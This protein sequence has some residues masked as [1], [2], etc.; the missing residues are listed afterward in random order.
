MLH[1]MFPSAQK[2]FRGACSPRRGLSWWP[3]DLADG[4]DGR[5]NVSGNREFG[6]YADLPAHLVRE[7]AF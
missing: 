2:Y 4:W 3:V 5:Y 6:Q 7:S 1:Y